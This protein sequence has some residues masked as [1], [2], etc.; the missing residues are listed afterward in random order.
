LFA[1]CDFTNIPGYLNFI[2][3]EAIEAI[4]ELPSFL[5]NNAINTETH[6]GNFHLCVRKWCHDI[7]HEDVKMSLFIFSLDGNVMDWFI[8]LPD[9]SFDS[10]E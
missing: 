8:D 4:E 5:G 6:L 9:N 1:P 7:N 3:D 10:I 2:S